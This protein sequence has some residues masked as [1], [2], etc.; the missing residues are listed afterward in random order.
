MAVRVMPTQS[1][2]ATQDSDKPQTYKLIV[3]IIGGIII[4]TGLAT[5]AILK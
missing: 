5:F 3:G 2:L 1:L 4:F